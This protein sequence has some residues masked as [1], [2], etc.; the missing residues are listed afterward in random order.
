MVLK[1]IDIEEF[2]NIVYPEYFKIF[3]KN[4]RKPLELIEK[5]Y[6]QG[7]AKIIKIVEKGEFVGFL[8]INT[9]K[10]NPIAL[11]DYFAIL[12]KYQSKGYGSKALHLLKAQTKEYKGIFI[13]IEKLGLGEDDKQNETRKKRAKFYERI[14]FLKLGFDLD[15]FKVIYSAY[16][17]PCTNKKFSDEEVIEEIFKIYNEIIGED[18]FKKNCKIIL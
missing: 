10:N 11:L 5:T 17:L 15:L 13:E 4:E 3:P 14:G 9:L 1:D 12:P 2:K 8:I 18:R 7:I 6:N 16:L